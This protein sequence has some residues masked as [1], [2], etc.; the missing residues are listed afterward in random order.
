MRIARSTVSIVL[1][2]LLLLGALCPVAPAD[3]DPVAG[4]ADPERTVVVFRKGVTEAARTL[5]LRLA[6]IPEWREIH[7]IPE[8]GVAIVEA[9]PHEE[10]ALASNPLVAWVGPD[11]V[12]QILSTVP[13][14]PEVPSMTNL[15]DIGV[16]GAWDTYPGS[17]GFSPSGP[18]TGAPI[19]VLDSGIDP[20][21]VEFSPLAA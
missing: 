9:M 2:T 14:D 4:I 6:G 5:S 19:A 18:F 21:H 13:D 7:R 20:D 3:A 16:F 12:V 8:I 15:D 1:G 10:R 17:G 11:Q